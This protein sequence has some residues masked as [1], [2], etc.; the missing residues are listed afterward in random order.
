MDGSLAM[1]GSTI[2]SRNVWVQE[3]IP[4]GY[5]KE[6]PTQSPAASVS[7]SAEASC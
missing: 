5:S 3:F 7:E 6:R 4:F 1:D 2:L